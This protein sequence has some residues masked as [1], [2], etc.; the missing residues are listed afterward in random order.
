[1]KEILNKIKNLGIIHYGFLDFKIL[2]DSYDF[3]KYRK[4]NSLDSS[5]EEQIIE[6][7]INF[8]NIM[9]DGKTIM[10]FAFPYNYNIKQSKNEYFSLYALGEDYHIV[11]KDY[12][13]EIASVIRN[14]GYKAKIFVELIG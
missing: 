7:R 12:L 14:K 4:D 1:M 8:E 10:S 6:N 11:V 5:F 13:E 9:E 2:H 3:F